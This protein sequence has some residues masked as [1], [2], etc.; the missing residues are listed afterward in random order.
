MEASRLARKGVEVGVGCGSLD[1]ASFA[2]VLLLSGPE[3]V[4]CRCVGTGG[5]E[6][7]GGAIR[8]LDDGV[9]GDRW[10]RFPLGRFRGVEVGV[11]SDGGL[12]AATGRLGFASFLCPILWSNAVCFMCRC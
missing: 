1:V 4:I 11:M 8:L 6:M 10:E 3:A 12:F 2:P 5:V 7:A 9:V